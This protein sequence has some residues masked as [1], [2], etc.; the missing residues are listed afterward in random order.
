M[1]V[2]VQMTPEQYKEI[3]RALL[4]NQKMPLPIAEFLKDAFDTAS[5]KAV[6][7][8]A[9]GCALTEIQDM[10]NDTEANNERTD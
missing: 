1:K 9:E 8:Y 10:F 7:R 2:K 3:G 4:K 5:R 6:R